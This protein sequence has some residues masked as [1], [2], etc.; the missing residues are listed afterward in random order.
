MKNYFLD[1]NE[2]KKAN[3]GTERIIEQ[4]RNLKATKTKIWKPDKF[5]ISKR[6]TKQMAFLEQ[7]N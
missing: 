6:M 5:Y 1:K 7:R 2:R 4:M 3:E